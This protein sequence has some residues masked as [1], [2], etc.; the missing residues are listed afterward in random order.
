[1]LAKSF[2][3]LFKL[4]LNFLLALEVGAWQ[5][6]GHLKQRFDEFDVGNAQ[7]YDPLQRDQLLGII[8]AGFGGLDGFNTVLKGTMQQLR[9]RAMS[10]VRA[11][12][13]RLSRMP[14]KA[15][16]TADVTVFEPA[17]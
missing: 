3:V 12:T 9:K 15:D 16:A 2:L 5:A 11:A 7:C 17:P 1:M 8:E 13:R 4:L 10:E 6:V 14:T